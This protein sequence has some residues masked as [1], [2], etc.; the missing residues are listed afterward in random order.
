VASADVPGLGPG[1]RLLQDPDDLL[2]R[3]PLAP[4]GGVLPAGSLA[5]SDIPAGP[6]SGE[7]VG[8]N[9]DAWWDEPEY[10][11]SKETFTQKD[12]C[13]RMGWVWR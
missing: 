9:L 1:V 2:L 4:Q 7:Q 6:V 8:L 13:L 5:D 11:T 12:V 3:E 10:Q